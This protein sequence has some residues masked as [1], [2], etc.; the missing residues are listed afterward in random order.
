[1]TNA[2]IYKNIPNT[3]TE[4]QKKELRNAVK[5][6]ISLNA[7]KKSIEAEMN[8]VRDTIIGMIRCFGTD[9][10]IVVGT[11][12]AILTTCERVS[13]SFKDLAEAHPRI[14]KKFS[15]LSKYDRLTVK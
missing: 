5:K 15:T 4:D 11:R 1:M 13:V 12:T 7:K 9:N 10:K 2:E 6:Y 3:M 14:A 8:D